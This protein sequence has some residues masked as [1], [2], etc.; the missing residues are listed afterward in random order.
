MIEPVDVQA[1]KPSVSVS[2]DSVGLRGIAYPVR[3]RRDAREVDLLTH[4]NIFVDLPA[5]RKGAD[6]SRKI[7]AINE[8]ILNKK[9]VPSIEDL[10]FQIAT[11]VMERLPYSTKCRV[12]ISADYMRE[13]ET[14]NGRN[15][16]ILPYK[17]DG[18]TDL[19][20]SGQYVKMVGVS[21]TGLNA[22]PCAMETTRSLISKDFPGNDELINKIPS[23]THN[24]RNHVK[25]RVQ[26]PTGEDIEADD[27]ILISEHVLGGSL[28]SLLKRQDEGEL[29]YRVHLNP[30]FVEDIVREISLGVLNRY[31]SF[32]D[33]TRVIV[34][35]ESDESIHPHNAYAEINTT[36][37]DLRKS[38]SK[39]DH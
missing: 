3:V 24:Q 14:A 13:T 22:C 33:H 8:I 26:V 29:V 19:Q 5:S 16:V 21:V 30:K 1:S 28:H 20:R 37:G 7:E 2:V 18:E 12:E 17:I 15:H 38:L 27:L 9:V 4:I 39:R 32:P 31:K 34:S 23:I 10:S 11:K 35:S 36:L 25:L 6:F